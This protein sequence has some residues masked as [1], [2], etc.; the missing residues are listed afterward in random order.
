MRASRLLSI[1]I[2]LQTRGRLSAVAL[3]RELEVSVRTI[4]R[5]VDELSAAGVPIF[6]ER[7]RN[8]GFALLDGYRTEVTGLTSTEVDAISLIGVAQAAKDLGL[9]EE[10]AA[11]RLKIFASLPK[12]KGSIA[13]RIAARF[14]VDA[15]PWYSHHTPPTALRPIASAVWS[16]RQ[17]RMTYESWS[18]IVVRTISPLGI[19]MKAG[20]WYVVGAIGKDVRTYRVDSIRQF[21]ITEKATTRP[22]AFD[23]A[24]Y[25][26]Q[27]AKEFETR[28]RSETAHVRLSPRGMEILRAVN[29]TASSQ[30]AKKKTTPSKD[31]WI[32]AHITVESLPG[33]VNE[34]LRFGAELEVLGPTELRTAVA[35]AAK[36]IAWLHTKT[37]SAKRKTF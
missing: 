5:Y 19:V 28:L 17:V 29:P 34:V 14:H 8:G 13:D 35:T 30:V 37:K 18:R 9:G 33:A 25:W 23:L 10:A 3:A 6:A 21:E 26:D 1:L 32:E 4:Y 12:E 16:D 27:A 22:R 2:V 36:R 24:R 11:A 20:A 31:G 15:V 7:G